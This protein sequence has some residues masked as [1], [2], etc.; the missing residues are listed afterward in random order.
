MTVEQVSK[1]DNEKKLLSDEVLD[2]VFDETNE[3]LRTKLLIALRDRAMALR[4]AG[5]FDM[6]V[7]AYKKMERQIAK[8]KRMAMS[9][10]APPEDHF[11]D[12]RIR[13]TR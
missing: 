2:E 10:Q 9:A 3:V 1:I 8:D 13:R 6:I 11:T 5:K 7:N 12:L 4:C